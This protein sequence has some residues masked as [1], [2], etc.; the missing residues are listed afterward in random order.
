MAWGVALRIMR[1]VRAD[2]R[3]FRFGPF[4]FGCGT[5]ELRKGG[6]KIRLNGQAVQVLTALLR[7]RRDSSDL[8]SATLECLKS[9]PSF[10]TSSYSQGLHTDPIARVSIFR[11]HLTMGPTGVPRFEIR[12]ARVIRAK[13]MLGD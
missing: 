13:L 9:L 7:S 5:G 12:H 6:T 8:K 2:D 3:G 10:H 1:T 4:E 11:D